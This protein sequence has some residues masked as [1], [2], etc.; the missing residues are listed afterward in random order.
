MQFSTSLFTVTFSTF[1]RTW[2]QKCDF[3]LPFGAQLGPKWHPK[4]PKWRQNGTLKITMLL[5]N[6]TSETDLVRRGSLGDLLVTVWLVWLHFG[7]FV[8]PSGSLLVPFSVFSHPFC[9]PFCRTAV[10]KNMQTLQ[11]H[12]GG[13]RKRQH[14]QQTPT[15][16]L[17]A[18]CKTQATAPERRLPKTGPAVLAPLGAFGSGRALRCAVGRFEIW[19]DV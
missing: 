19:V 18:L 6:A 17:S 7:S 16:P 14:H 3:W 4:S 10:S 2:C 13:K 1:W 8:A 9:D 15:D 5:P 12:A 11:K